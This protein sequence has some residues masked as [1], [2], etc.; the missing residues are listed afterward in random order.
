[1]NIYLMLGLLIGL[2]FCAGLI[3]LSSE[4]LKQKYYIS[5]AISLAHLTLSF[6]LFTGA[7]V[8]ESAPYFSFDG[9]SRFFLLILS[10]VFFWVSLNSYSYITR[11]MPYDTRNSKKLFFGLINLYLAA[12]TLALLSNHW[13]LYWVALETTTLCTAPLI[14]YYHSRQSLEAMWKYLFVVSVGI[15]FAFMGIIFLALSSK[16]VSGVQNELFFDTL[17]LNAQKLNPVWLKAAFIFIFVG[18]S[19]KI[20]IAPMHPGEVDAVSNSP[21]PAAA[22][23]S[24]TLNATALL[25]LLRMLQVVTKTQVSSFSRTLMITGGVLSLVVAF[26][27][28]FRVRNYKRMIAYSSVEHFGLI[29]IGVATGGAALF[30]A[31]LQML[32]NSFAKPSLFFMAGNIHSHYHSRDIEDIKGLKKKLKWT[33]LLFTAAFLAVAALPPFGIFFSELMIFQGLI[34]AGQLPLL[35][36]V[37]ILLLLVFIAISRLAFRMLYTPE[38]PAGQV[39][40]EGSV[41]AEKF[42]LSHLSVVLMLT[43]LTILGVFLPGEI[44]AAVSEI[45]TLLK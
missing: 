34:E 6:L 17:S 33:A 27:Y 16:G 32:Y 31:M 24:S 20:G 2:P 43:V 13:G 25:G 38:E 3:M 4:K 11:T 23:I 14:Y 39:I 9:L 18:L 22:L 41:R 30:G 28:L 5:I 45:V 7:L 37:L 8:P 26:L 21:S 1:M 10:N 12:N 15:A 44:F 40:D 29:V 19:T 36:V 42:G 35:A